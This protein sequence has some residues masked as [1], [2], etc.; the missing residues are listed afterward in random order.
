MAFAVMGAIRLYI[1]GL[2]DI[3]PASP[4]VGATARPRIAERRCKTDNRAPADWISPR[5]R[6]DKDSPW[7]C[8]LTASKGAKRVE[9][10]TGRRKTP[11]GMNRSRWKMCLSRNIDLR[12]NPPGGSGR[13]RSLH[14]AP[15]F[16]CSS[17]G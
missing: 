14:P 5:P 4:S 11:P 12:S 10:A 9:A 7:F 17:S 2:C 6:G 15:H 8:R 16:V 1:Y 13:F 3:R